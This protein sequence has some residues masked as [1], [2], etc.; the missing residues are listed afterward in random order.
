M[1]ERTLFGTDGVRGYVNQS[2]MTADTVLQIGMAAGSLFTNGPHRHQVIIGKD[3]RISGYLLEQSLAA[4][5]ISVGMDVV[6]V[7]PMPTPAIGMLTHALRADLGVMISASHNPFHDNGIKLFGPN[8]YKLSDAEEGEIEARVQAL[9]KDPS[10]FLVTPELLGRAKRLEDAAGRYIEHV[11]SAF[12]K[13]LRLSSLKIVIDCAHGAAYHLGPTILWELGAE[14]IPIGVQPN[15]LNINQEC[16]S[17]HTEA[18]ARAVKE[19]HADLGIALDGDADRVIIVDEQARVVDGDQLIAAIASFWHE[20]NRIKGNVVVAT[21]MSNMG[22][23]LY[24]K[25]QGITLERTKVGD[26]YVVERMRENGANIG[27]EQSGHIILRDYATTGDGLIAALQLLAILVLKQK[28]ASEIC[29]RF[30]PFPQQ[31][32]N[33]RYQGSSPL[34]HPAVKASIEAVERKLVG[35]GRLL[36]R[37]S[38]TESLIRVMAE[39]RDASLTQE[40]IHEVTTVIKSHIS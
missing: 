30:E 16:G 36:V 10:M 8:G 14:V 25:E 17:L 13:E 1:F 6:L 29:H 28:R 23:E 37:K 33:I 20:T 40:A 2:P 4:G 18:L 11:K 21:Q 22:L 24:L 5:F 7:G 26:R 27:G 15:G 34:E 38:G 32:F 35:K 9:R 3:T 19:H 39:A 12:P 31:L